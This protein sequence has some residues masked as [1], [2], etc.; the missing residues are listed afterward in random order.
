MLELEHSGASDLVMVTF[1]LPRHL[2]EAVSVVGEFNDWDP[3]ATP[4]QNSDGSYRA[5]IS[6]APGRYR[7]RYL[8]ADGRWFN[9]EAAHDYQT[10][11]YG[12]ADSVLDT[13]TAPPVRP[14]GIAEAADAPPATEPVGPPS[15]VRVKRGPRK[16]SPAH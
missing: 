12:G 5:T 1:V 8:A 2:A 14:A 3:A 11:D 7:F 10:N 4:M 16:R 15:A 9:D 6:L 13:A